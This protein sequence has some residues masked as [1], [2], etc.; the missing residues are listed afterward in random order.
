M[1]LLHQFH[2]SV[3]NANHIE[4][5]PQPQPTH[6]F[7]PLTPSLFQ[8]SNSR[9][10]LKT[11][12]DDHPRK[13]CL[14]HATLSGHKFE[15]NN[16]T[17]QRSGNQSHVTK[18]TRLLLRHLVTPQQ[19]C[20]QCISHV[21]LSNTSILG[22]QLSFLVYMDDARCCQDTEAKN[23]QSAIGS[24]Q[25]D[26]CGTV[27]A[28]GRY[29]LVSASF[30]KPAGHSSTS[31]MY[32]FGVFMRRSIGV[33]GSVLRRRGRRSFWRRLKSRLVGR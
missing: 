20:T 16:S 1:C 29:S 31:R 22:I 11:L 19:S 3:N 5:I 33:N 14:I 13:K 8:Y 24:R 10:H 15:A 12:I 28:T 7:H 23:S 2:I 4:P 6:C 18:E 21:P 17:T 26:D 9:I 30:V 25:P 27:R 32:A